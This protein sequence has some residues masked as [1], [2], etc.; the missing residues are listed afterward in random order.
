[1]VNTGYMHMYMYMHSKHRPV[2]KRGSIKPPRL[3]PHPLNAINLRSSA[4]R[5]GQMCYVVS[6]VECINWKIASN[7]GHMHQRSEV[8]NKDKSMSMGHE[9]FT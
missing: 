9:Q 2:A 7:H 1:M 5:V 3:L 6:I 8:S 4:H